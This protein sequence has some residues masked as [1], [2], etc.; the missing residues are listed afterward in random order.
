[1]LGGSLPCALQ[2]FNVHL[3]VD[4]LSYTMEQGQRWGGAFTC[5][6]TQMSYCAPHHILLNASTHSKTITNILTLLKLA[7]VTCYI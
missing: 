5:H 1:M 3:A 4:Y 6:A 7:I 2:S